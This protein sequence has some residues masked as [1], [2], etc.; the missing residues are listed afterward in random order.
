VLVIAFTILVIFLW[1]K[2]FGFNN[3]LW[4]VPIIAAIFGI[5]F[6][7][8]LLLCCKQYANRMS[9]RKRMLMY[10]VLQSMDYSNSGQNGIQLRPGKEGTDIEIGTA[11]SVNPYRPDPI[12]MSLMKLPPGVSSIQVI[13]PSNP[14]TQ[15]N[16]PPVQNYPAGP[17]TTNNYP[18]QP[19][20]QNKPPQYPTSSNPQTMPAQ[21]PTITTN[22][23]PNNP[24]TRPAGGIEMTPTQP[25]PQNHS[26]YNNNSASK[27]QPNSAIDA[28]ANASLTTSNM[29]PTVTA[30]VLSPQP[31]SH[32][33]HI[34][35]KQQRFLERLKIQQSG[36][37]PPPLNN[38]PGR[39][40][41]IQPEQE[42][43]YDPS[44]S[45]NLLIENPDNDL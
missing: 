5:C 37:K 18:Q 34:T 16:Q 14:P 41:S 45:I 17:T 21:P 27:P 31:L 22:T 15:P 35:P 7:G 39:Y 36:Q 4:W 20:T 12:A 10:R 9:W 11:N 8:V 24:T 42:F 38:A 26:L 28:T 43:I 32:P 33:V 19:P 23:Y 25:P 2:E 30:S 1:R 44:K 6:G 29:K 13:P 40:D 3:D